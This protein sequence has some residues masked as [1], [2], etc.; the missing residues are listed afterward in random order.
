[1]KAL[2]GSMLMGGFEC[3]AHKLRNGKRLDIT[4]STGHDVRA[5]EDFG[6]LH[7]HGIT[8]ARD[9][10]RWHLIERRT[11]QYDWNS[12]LPMVRAAR[13]ARTTVVWDLL[14]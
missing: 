6:L 8:A 5:A 3:A 7:R 14:H 10:L 9:G 13:D 12:F 2:F 11:G 4:A 1:M